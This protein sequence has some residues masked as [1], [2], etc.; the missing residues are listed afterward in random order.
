[1]TR[2]SDELLDVAELYSIFFTNTTYNLLGCQMSHFRCSQMISQVDNIRV[3]LI[4]SFP[5]L[6]SLWMILKQEKGGNE[7]KESIGKDPQT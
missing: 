7:E 2:K 5:G 1:V 6:L 3:R 4:E